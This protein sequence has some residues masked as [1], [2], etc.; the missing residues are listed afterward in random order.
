MK[1][2]V[3]LSTAIIL[4]AGNL[5]A[6]RHADTSTRIL[7]PSFRTLKIQNPL[8]FYAPPIIGSDGSSHLAISFDELAEDN[9]YL[10][11][12]LI[13]CNADWQ[14]SQ[15]L[16]S[17][18][19][20]GFNMEDIDDYA[21]S[22]NTFVH[23]VNYRIVIPNEKMT[24]LVSGNYLLQVFPDDD[25]DKILLQARFCVSE[26]LVNITAEATT[27]TDLGYNGDYQQ[28]NITIDTESH[29]IRDP[30]SDLIVTVEQN[31]RHDNMA[32]VK[33]PL[34]VNGHK[35]IYE[36]NRD[37]IF[38]A[39]N[40][41]RRF[42]TVR[43]NYPGMH[44]D[45]TRYIGNNY[46]AFLSIDEE[47]ASSSYI[48]DQTQFGRFMVRE[49]NSSDS[50]LGADYITTHFTLDFPEILD[51]DVYIDGEF[52]H[53]RFDDTNRMR[54][55]RETAMY[56]LPIILKQ[57]SYNYQYLVRQKGNDTAA[58]DNK[59]IEGNHYETNNEYTIKV[60]Q[61]EPGSRGDRLIG[62]TTIHTH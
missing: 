10:R 24:P 35:L 26:N 54:Y 3:S 6:A 60:Y 28:I 21:F 36:H 14:P 1:I 2:L 55:N 29:K 16:E 11:Y 8:N 40:E 41:F 44:T 47:R 62:A 32:I 43:A 37:L 61:R 50:D 9:R 19:I 4:A 53:H 33:T 39:S 57:G 48:Y 51:G 27:S 12:R 34:R 20:D 46:H 7:E 31:G 58:A 56:E 30:F 18:Y 38:Q 15:L 45:S 22:Y 25:Y 13:H 17:E 59:L 5:A 23:Y 52:T 49:Y 42:E